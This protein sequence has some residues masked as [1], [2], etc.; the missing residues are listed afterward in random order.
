MTEKIELPKCLFPAAL[1]VIKGATPNAIEF[2]ITIYGFDGNEIYSNKKTN[3]YALRD[4][5]DDEL[6][7]DVGDYL[8]EAWRMEVFRPNIFETYKRPL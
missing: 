4:N 5:E 3:T 2:E 7:S 1:A 6:I 8:C